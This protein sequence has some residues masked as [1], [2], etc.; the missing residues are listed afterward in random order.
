MLLSNYESYL[1]LI[2]RYCNKT[3]NI[4]IYCIFWNIIRTFVTRKCIKIYM[5]AL[6]VEYKNERIKVKKG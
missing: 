1:K 5:C 3:F 6:Y 2:L 4:P